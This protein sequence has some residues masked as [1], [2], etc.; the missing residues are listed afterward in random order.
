MNASRTYGAMLVTVL[1]GLPAMALA[2]PDFSIEPD[3]AGGVQARAGWQWSFDQHAVEASAAARGD[4]EG[5][6][7]SYSGAPGGVEEVNLRASPT[8]SYYGWCA[9]QPDDTMLAAAVKAPLRFVWKNREVTA[10]LGGA[11]L[12]DRWAYDQDKL[13]YNWDWTGLESKEDKNKEPRLGADGSAATVPA[14]P[15]AQTVTF[16]GPYQPIVING[17][18]NTVVVNNQ[19]GEGSNTTTTDDN[20]AQTQGGGQ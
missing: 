13:W 16:S 12:V 4:L 9:K 5:G 2:G 6:P 10:A 20:G 7:A 19:N 14:L 18:G 17:N 15:P 1:I 8:S 11:A 3:G